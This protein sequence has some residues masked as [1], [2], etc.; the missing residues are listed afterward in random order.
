MGIFQMVE[1]FLGFILN[2]IPYYQT[3]RLAFFI[4]MAAPQTEGHKKVYEAISPYIRK[5]KDEI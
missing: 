3:V 2:F 1:M 5:H 4:Y